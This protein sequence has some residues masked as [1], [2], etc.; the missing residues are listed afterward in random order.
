DGPE[1]PSADSP[2]ATEDADA[3]TFEPEQDEDR[4][5]DRSQSE[6]EDEVSDNED[7]SAPVAAGGADGQDTAGTVLPFVLG[8]GALLL[9]GGAGVWLAARQL[10]S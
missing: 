4:S 10:K 2:D 1:P 6:D 5:T 3:A 9:L 8:G 7:S